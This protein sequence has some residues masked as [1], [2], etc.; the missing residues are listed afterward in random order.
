MKA[1]SKRTYLF[2]LLFVVVACN[3]R[4]KHE[5]QI[6]DNLQLQQ[7]VLKVEVLAS[8]MDVPWDLHY[9]ADDHLW[10]TE[11]GGT[12]WRIDATTGERKQIL[13]IN[14]VWRK[15]T[16][17]LLGITLHPDFAT[18]PFVFVNYTL[19]RDSVIFSRLER[20]RFQN[21][22]LIEPTTVLEIG[23]NT[24]HNGSRLTIST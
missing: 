6:I 15:R 16:A 17:G 13:Q 9:G 7:T 4:N 2:F 18:Q 1:T 10:V 3:N 8:E 20:Y 23:G 21:D 11:Q 22:T 5:L 24:A 12:V 19:L 14:D